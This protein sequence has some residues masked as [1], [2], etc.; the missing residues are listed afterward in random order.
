L[1]LEIR[2]F[3]IEDISYLWRTMNVFLRDQRLI[4][5]RPEFET[6][7]EQNEHLVRDRWTA[8]LDGQVVGFSQFWK[9]NNKYFIFVAVLPEAR[10]HGIED[11]LLERAIAEV[12]NTN[13][14][15]A[16]KIA[17]CEVKIKSKSVL[18]RLNLY[19]FQS[20]QFHDLE[21]RLKLENIKFATLA[22]FSDTPETRE[23]LY[24]LVRQSVEDDA[25]FEGEF[26]TLEQ[27]NEYIWKIY[28]DAR[29]NWVLA[30]DGSRFVA[31]AGAY[32][33][34]KVHVS[35]SEML[36]RTGLTGVA[37]SHRRRG[38]AQIV[39]AKSTQKVLEVAHILLPTIIETSN[40]SGN[41]AMLA[42]N[43]KLGFQYVGDRYWLEII[44]D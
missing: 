27:F 13:L 34:E 4:G 23:N 8:I 30:I 38:L 36:W 19:D 32:E 7:Q 2:K 29:D 14:G 6:E 25:G 24:Q 41:A 26:E 18:S 15:P 20:S 39:K 3:E 10:A 11:I 37:R 22:N 17:S 12:Q 5:F 35:N 33:F 42:I 28:W 21:Q 43:H 16:H 9:F 1:N 31:L 44:V 40:D